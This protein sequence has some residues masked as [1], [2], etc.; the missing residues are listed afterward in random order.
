MRRLFLIASLL[1]L[2]I[3]FLAACDV[4]G[5]PPELPTA[6]P[7][8]ANPESLSAVPQ[9]TQA[10][11]TAERGFTPL[12]APPGR[13]YFVRASGL[14]SVSPDGSGLAKLSE[15]PPSNPPCLSPDGSRVAFTS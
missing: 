14:W 13:I 11:P 5:P 3:G 10:P 1:A 9:R 15:L 2:C 6:T 12:A 7:G 4:P 8:S